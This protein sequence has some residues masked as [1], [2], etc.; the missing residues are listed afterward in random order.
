MSDENETTTDQTSDHG[1]AADERPAGTGAGRTGLRDRLRR[2]RR[3]D[4]SR[5][6]GL[7]SLIAATLAGVIVGGLSGAAIHAAV[8]GDGGDHGHRADWSGMRMGGGHGEREGA[9]MRPPGGPGQLPPTTEPDTT[10]EP[11]SSGQSSNS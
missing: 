11:G 2:L 6:F 7:G 8:D 3:T 5:V 4:G 1:A 9:P 10:T